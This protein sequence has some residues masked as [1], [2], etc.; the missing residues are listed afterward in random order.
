[1][2]VEE[3]EQLLTR[4]YM[5]ILCTMLSTNFGLSGCLELRAALHTHPTW[6]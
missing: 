4:V 2:Q 5:H 3:N 1:M 6:P